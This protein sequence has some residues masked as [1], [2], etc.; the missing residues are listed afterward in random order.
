MKTVH[1][2]STDISMELELS[3]CGVLVLKKGK[4]VELNGIAL[5]NGQLMKGDDEHG[6]KCMCNV[7]LDKLKERH[8][9]DKFT[10]EYK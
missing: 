4:I 8:I 1:V 6:Y 5:P 7:E 9:K 10:S 2:F 3:K